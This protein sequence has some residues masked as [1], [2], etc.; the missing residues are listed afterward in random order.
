[1][2]YAVAVTKL[3]KMAKIITKI[4]FTEKDLLALIAEKYNLKLDGAKISIYKY[5][6]DSREPSYTTI[7]VEGE[8]SL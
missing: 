3:K 5:D 1:M 4:E 2:L 8:K 6:G 7:T